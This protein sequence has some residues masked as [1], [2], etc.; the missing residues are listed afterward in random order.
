MN[1][2]LCDDDAE[3]LDNI[4][5]EI[6]HWSKENHRQIDLIHAFRSPE[7]FIDSTKPFSYDLYILDID[8]KRDTD[9]YTLAKIIRNNQPE[10]IIVFLSNYDTYLREGY[11]IG[12]LRYYRK[13]VSSFEIYSLLNYCSRKL[14]SLVLEVDVLNEQKTKILP[15]N[16]I[17]Y[18]EY[19]RHQITIYT[20]KGS[21]TTRLYG[22]FSDYLHKLPAGYFAFSCQSYIVNLSKVTAYTNTEVIL[23]EKYT[24]P[25]SRH[26]RNS[27]IEAL[28]LSML[29]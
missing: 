5:S 6:E 25:I 2:C 8:F 28:R 19:A 21:V 1:V 3:F 27:L 12:I 29:P 15:V 9:G 16:T 11:E 14:S 10:A 24:I 13:P 4:L 23:S 7:D 22:S 26:Y 17:F 20:S 18:I